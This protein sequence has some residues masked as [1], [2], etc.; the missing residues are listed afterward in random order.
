MYQQL[1]PQVNLGKF[2]ST[3]QPPSSN[4]SPTSVLLGCGR[5]DGVAVVA[6]DEQAGRLQGG[7]KVEGGVE[8]T[9]A[10]GALAKIGGCH[11]RR[12]LQ[13]WVRQ[14]GKGEE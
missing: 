8:I 14:G 13:L 10:G 5:A 1:S 4:P 7:G 9:F 11:R 6:A 3:K 12:L 2:P